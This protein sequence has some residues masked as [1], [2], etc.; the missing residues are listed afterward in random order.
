[1]ITSAEFSTRDLSSIIRWTKGSS[2]LKNE[3][4]SEAAREHLK[5]RG[6]EPCECWQCKLKIS[7]H[8]CFCPQKNLLKSMKDVPLDVNQNSYSGPFFSTSPLKWCN[9]VRV[10]WQGGTEKGNNLRLFVS[11]IDSK[12]NTVMGLSYILNRWIKISCI[13]GRQRTR[14]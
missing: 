3:E 13:I 14:I 10:G 4:D 9:Q 5:L 12:I 2:S 1:M 11:Y 8:S 6:K 7:A